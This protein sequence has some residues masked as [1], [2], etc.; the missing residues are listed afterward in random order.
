MATE[1]RDD[2]LRDD[3][4]R[5]DELKLFRFKKKFVIKKNVD[6]LLITKMYEFSRFYKYNLRWLF[7]S[8]IW[9]RGHRK[10]LLIEFLFTIFYSLPKR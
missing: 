9:E 3:E 1:L 5:D 10:I 4:L 2:E 8:K 6:L 7:P